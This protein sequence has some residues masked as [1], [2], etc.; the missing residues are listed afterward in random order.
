MAVSEWTPHRG[1]QT[2]LIRA[3]AH[4]VTRVRYLSVPHPTIQTNW[5]VG[6]G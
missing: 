4:P 5:R 6:C 2:N 1:G 3:L